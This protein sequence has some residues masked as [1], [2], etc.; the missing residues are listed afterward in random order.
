MLFRSI[1]GVRFPTLCARHKN[2]WVTPAM[3][4]FIA[5]LGENL[6]YS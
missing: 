3:E 1:S 2:R 6:S 4:L 5:L